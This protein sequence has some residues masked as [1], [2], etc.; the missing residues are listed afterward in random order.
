M[1]F[2]FTITFSVSSSLLSMGPGP[3]IGV[4]FIS[5]I[6]VKFLQRYDYS[7]IPPNAGNVFCSSRFVKLGIIPH[8]YIYI[9][10]NYK[11]NSSKFVKT[12]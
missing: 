7:V 6:L 5:L 10:T 12:V 3:V 2:Y 1:E 4:V 9:T 8:L 11:K